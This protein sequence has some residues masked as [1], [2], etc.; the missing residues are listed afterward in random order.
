[1]AGIQ[2]L[3][4]S[5]AAI[6]QALRGYDRVIHFDCGRGDIPG[7]DL[8]PTGS[9]KLFVVRLHAF[10]EERL[11]GS[12]VAGST[13]DLRPIAMLSETVIRQKV[14]NRLKIGRI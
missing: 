4:A 14:C 10:P 8:R 9:P 2:S 11:V 7:I 13:P 5:I 3:R 6:D 12:F 1:M